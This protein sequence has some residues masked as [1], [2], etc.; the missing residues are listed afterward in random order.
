VTVEKLLEL[1]AENQTL[2]I[3]LVSCH[4]CNVVK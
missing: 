3:Q 1:D 4:A 2:K